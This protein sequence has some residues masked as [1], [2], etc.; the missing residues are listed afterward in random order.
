MPTPLDE[1]G[2]ARLVE[3][4]VAAAKRAERA[5]FDFVEIHGAHGYLIQEFLSPLSNKR[6]DRYGGPLENRMR[7]LL[8]VVACGARGAAVAHDGRREAFGA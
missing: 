5:G 7:L 8:E 6:D 4:F 2:I 1:D 3:N